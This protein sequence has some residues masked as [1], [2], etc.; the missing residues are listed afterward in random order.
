MHYLHKK[1][2][3]PFHASKTPEKYPLKTTPT[4]GEI[5]QVRPGKTHARPQF[6]TLE[7]MFLR[8]ER[9]VKN[10]LVKSDECF[11]VFSYQV[12]VN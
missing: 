12:R 9:A 7:I 8:H 1:N 5:L 6:L 3:P 10:L 2:Q 11:P 4:R